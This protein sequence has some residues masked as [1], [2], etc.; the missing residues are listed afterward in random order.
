[1]G[2]IRIL[3]DN[4]ANKIAAGEVVERP[5]S[6]VKELLENSLDA[7]A[8]RVRVEI[9][10]GGKKLIRVTDD[11]CGMVRDDAMLAF[12]RHATSKLRTADDL[13]SV[14]TL[15]F[16]GE[17]LP[18]IAAVSRLLLETR[19]AEE[20][21]G[22]RIEV[23][24]GRMLEVKEAG[25]PAGTSVTAR[26]LFYNIPARRKFLRSESTEAAHI[27]S[28]VTHYALAHP[29][30]HVSLASG[31]GE[32]LNVSPVA[33]ERERMFQVFGAETLD[34]LVELGEIE[35]ELVVPPPTSAAPPGFTPAHGQP[36]SESG[37]AGAAKLLKL[38]GFISRP[39]FQKPNRNS[40]FIFVNRRLIRD[41]LIL[42]A[43]GEAYRNLI[44][45]GTFPLALLFLGIPFDEVDVNVHP[46]KTEVRF[47]H[48]GFVHDFVRD[49][50]RQRLTASRPVSTFPMTAPPVLEP[51]PVFPLPSSRPPATGRPQEE[52]AGA[53]F[54]LRPARLEPQNQ[55]F[56]FGAAPPL[57]L[58]RPAPREA[59]P[60]EALD[61][62]ESAP[63]E[64]GE[65]ATHHPPLAT[66]LAGLRPLG[67]IKE[68]F[69]VAASDDALWIVDQ[70][71]A[72]ERVLFEQTLRRRKSGREQGQRLLMPIIIQLT[73]QQQAAL[74]EIRAELEANGF[75]IEPFGRRT[76]AVKSSPAGID[77]AAVEKMLQE[78]LDGIDAT[79]CSPLDDA[80]SRV[81]ASIACHA[82]IKVNMPLDAPKMQW[83]LDEL[84]RTEAPMS[85]PHGRPVILRYDLREILR[86]FHRL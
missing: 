12:E 52:P 80:R 70:H 63:Q 82:A 74:D 11:G 6:V 45:A 33:T 72:H 85:C 9:E 20:A 73:P 48:Q 22:T 36:A 55:R 30:R 44:A 23:H 34:E 32:L 39:Q 49:A 51:R 1:M 71:V 28:L 65:L 57:D 43:L 17:A 15:G 4:I 50:L 83:L 27:A 19:A 26:D 40:I 54:H 35:T 60:G 64:Y 79:H 68:S 56:P 10:A 42:H 81:A 21:S 53:E 14:A 41:R 69:I 8:V 24:G 16:R 2:K 67:Q 84:A 38:S 46:S 18:S 13:M 5:A 86:A 61:T 29:E 25:L 31:T 58:P 78:L 7:D 3:P 59:P 76:V 77:A 75:E 37:S 62:A 47:R 66:D